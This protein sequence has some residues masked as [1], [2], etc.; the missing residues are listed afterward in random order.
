MSRLP[1]VGGDLDVWGTVLNDFLSVSHAADGT[2]KTGLIS[3]AM[4]SFDPATQAELD[5]SATAQTGIAAG[6]ALAL[7]S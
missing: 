6:L 2:I 4:L 5:A 1:V 7:G 3:V